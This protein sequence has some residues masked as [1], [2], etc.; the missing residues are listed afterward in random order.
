MLLV[1][2]VVAVVVVESS[3]GLAC[4]AGITVGSGLALPD[5]NLSV[6]F[7]TLVRTLSSSGVR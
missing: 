1:E 7:P 6:S 2:V 4:K 5:A 3:L